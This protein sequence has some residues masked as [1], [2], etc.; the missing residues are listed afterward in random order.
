VPLLERAVAESPQNEVF[1]RALG[2]Y[3]F[4][5]KDCPG[6]AAV[7]APFEQKTSDPTTLNSLA[8]FLTCLGKR[9]DA[10]VLLER[11]LA[12]KPDQP[13]AIQS[14]NILRNGPPQGSH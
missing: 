8:L 1:A 13:G 10:I 2:L 14:L 9:Q 4:K 12:L 5:H 3:R 7:V 11:S 6:A